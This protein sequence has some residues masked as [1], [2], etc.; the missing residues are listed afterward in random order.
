MWVGRHSVPEQG[1]PLPWEARSQ[2][3]GPIKACPS[4]LES[5]TLLRSAAS[6]ESSPLS[7]VRWL[8][9]AGAASLGFLPFRLPRPELGCFCAGL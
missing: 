7:S 3:M 9:G 1:L 2:K 5:G 4:A 8:Q 6:L